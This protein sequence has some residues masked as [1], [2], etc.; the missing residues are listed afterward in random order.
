M[1]IR[2]TLI[3]LCLISLSVTVYPLIVRGGAAAEKEARSSEIRELL[4]GVE[5]KISG[6]RSLKTGFVQEKNLAV[7]KSRITIRGRIYLQKP[8]RIAWHVDDPVRYSVVISDKSVRQWDEDTGRVQEISLSGNPVFRSFMDQMAVWFSGDYISLLKDYEVEVLQRSPLVLGF[9]P[10]ENNPAVK[11]I[12][13]ITVGLREDEKYL[14]QIT[15]LESSGDSTTIIFKDTVFDAP[16]DSS[17]F[18]VKR[19]VR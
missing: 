1:N 8:G 7:F 10:K 9:T 16:I 3:F 6:F 15:I 12:K 4:S 11:I 2:K 18:E 5:Q 17:D 14:K 19:R 13:K